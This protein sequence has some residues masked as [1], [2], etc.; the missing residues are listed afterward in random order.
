MSK[1]IKVKHNLEVAL[2]KLEKEDRQVLKQFEKLDNRTNAF[3][4]ITLGIFSLQITLLTG[5]IISIYEKYML[6]NNYLAITLIII[7][8]VNILFNING[9]T[10]FRKSSKISEE[11]Y[12]GRYNISDFNN[13]KFNENDLLKCEIIGY[14]DTISENEK[15]VKYKKKYINRGLNSIVLS[16]F[17]IF[18]IMIFLFLLLGNRAVI[19]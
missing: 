15:K 5:N 4:S 10:N 2:Q 19:L 11:I 1:N 6:N 14:Q 12:S 13:N 7:F 17:L 9:I 8:L 18:T 3:F 16:M